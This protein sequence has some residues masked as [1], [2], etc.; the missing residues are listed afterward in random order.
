[1]LLRLLLH[2]TTYTNVIIYCNNSRDTFKLNECMLDP[3]PQKAHATSRG[4]CRGGG[5]GGGGAKGA[6]DPLSFLS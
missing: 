4:G 5:G 3:E 2:T 1:M 6:V